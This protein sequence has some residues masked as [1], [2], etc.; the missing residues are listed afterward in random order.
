MPHG[1]GRLILPVISGIE[2]TNKNLLQTK[3]IRVE[4]SEKLS[5]NDADLMD[6]MDGF[7]SK[8]R[9]DNSEGMSV[10]E[11][12]FINGLFS[13]QWTEKDGNEYEGFSNLNR[14]AHGKCKVKYASGDIYD[15]DWVYGRKHG[16]GSY[17]S[18]NGPV[19]HTQ[20]VD[21]KLAEYKML[22]EAGYQE[23]Y[24]EEF[25]QLPSILE[26]EYA[27]IWSEGAPNGHGKL[28][29]NNGDSFE[30]L[31]VKGWREGVGTL[32]E[33]DGTEMTANWK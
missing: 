30:G 20:W 32:I 11:G 33:E 14:Q 4:S 31:F 27:G 17:S 26:C 22:C 6:K 19:F 24:K 18:T 8:Q 15:G 3:G 13:W 12:T 21:D 10:I 2:E 9:T 28:R 23:G 7:L 29:F 5:F 1:R 16:R 25:I